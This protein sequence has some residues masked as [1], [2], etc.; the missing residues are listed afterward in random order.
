MKLTGRGPF[1][2]ESHFECIVFGLGDIILSIVQ[3]I[4]L[5]G[6]ELKLREHIVTVKDVYVKHV[7]DR[8]IV[9]SGIVELI[10]E[11]D[12]VELFG[13]DQMVHEQILAVKKQHA[14][15][16]VGPQSHAQFAFTFGRRELLVTHVGHTEQR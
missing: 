14:V 1:S 11:L 3:V 6:F 7:S 13:G 2:F 4:V 8:V 12:D 16:P 5:A 15:V 9:V 10:A